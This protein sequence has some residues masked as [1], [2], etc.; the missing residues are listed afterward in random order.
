MA[1]RTGLVSHSLS[2]LCLKWSWWSQAQTTGVFSK[3]FSLTLL[4]L[5]FSPVE[6]NFWGLFW[7][8]F[9]F[10]VL[11][12]KTERKENSRWEVF[13]AWVD[14]SRER[15]P[16]YHWY[17]PAP[18]KDKNVITKEDG[19]R[20][21]NLKLF[22]LSLPKSTALTT[23]LSSEKPI[24]SR[25]VYLWWSEEIWNLYFA[26]NWHIQTAM[27][28]AWLCRFFIRMCEKSFNFHP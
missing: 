9:H 25:G 4:G 12:K 20:R 18:N 15:L 14:N 17:K 10:S 24:S 6:N 27:H 16:W 28:S 23:S 3:T 19:G 21:R 7:I 2:E 5:I 8:I 26:H 1:V 13:H 22:P 11:N